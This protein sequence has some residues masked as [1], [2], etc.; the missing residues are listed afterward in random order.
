M[1]W[2]KAQLL[3]LQL[4]LQQ[5]PVGHLEFVADTL[6]QKIAQAPVDNFLLLSRIAVPGDHLVGE[7]FAAAA[8]GVTDAG[9]TDTNT[10]S[11][12]GAFEHF[13]RGFSLPA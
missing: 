10:R 6:R 2:H 7:A 8:N 11:F 3:H 9:G 4:P 13:L 12:N 5:C 1:M